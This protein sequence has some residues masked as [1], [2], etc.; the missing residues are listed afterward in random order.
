MSAETTTAKEMDKLFFSG[1]ASRDSVV[2]DDAQLRENLLLPILER[3]NHTGRLARCGNSSEDFDDFF[4]E[5][6]GAFLYKVLN[7]SGMFNGEMED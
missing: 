2:V 1:L 6:F 3:I 4:G 5:K 7:G